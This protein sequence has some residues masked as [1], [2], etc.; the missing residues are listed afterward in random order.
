MRQ[1]L[2][3]FLAEFNVTMLGTKPYSKGST[4]QAEITIRFVKQA[5]RQ[6]VLSH[7][8]TWPEV[9]PHIFVE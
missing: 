7:V 2:D 8:H 3:G 9:L 6:L 1:D 5:L 4:A